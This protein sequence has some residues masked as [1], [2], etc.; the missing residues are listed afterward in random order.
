MPLQPY[1]A[2]TG[3]LLAPLGTLVNIGDS[4][5][6]PGIV[7]GTV[8]AG[9]TTVTGPNGD[10]F[11][12]TL[13][14]T[15]A[16]FSAGT[17]PIGVNDYHQSSYT[18]EL[19]GLDTG[20][21]SNVTFSRLISTQTQETIHLH[22]KTLSFKEDVKGWVSFKSFV[23]DA[24]IS[25]AS[26]YYTAFNGKLFKHHIEHV[27]RNHFYGSDYNSSINVILN[28]GPGSVKSFHTL[29]YEGSQSKV[30]GLKEMEIQDQA[31]ITDSTIT[32]DPQY[33]FFKVEDLNDI[34]EISNWNNTVFSIKHYTS[35]A[36]GKLLLGTIDVKAWDLT[37]SDSSQV[38]GWGYLEKEVPGGPSFQP[39]DIITTQS[40]EDSVEHFNMIPKDGWYVSN[41]ETNKQVGSLSEFIEKEG[42]WFNY[43]K[44][45]DSDIS[46]ESD[47]GAF[48]IQGLGIIKDI[49]SNKIFLDGDLNSS[50]Q[51]GDTIY[52]Q[53]ALSSS[54]HYVFDTIY[55]DQLQSAGVVS[56]IDPQSNSFH[57]VS[58]SGLSISVGDYIMF[59]KNHVV[60]MS[61][62]VGYFADVKF[63]N[64]S[65]DKVELFSVGSEIT[66]SS[67]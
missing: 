64:D 43:I 29:D 65:T 58:I 16:P 12:I 33:A 53:T 15:P 10:Y 38:M 41:I 3:I 4:V 62:L 11:E 32:P 19:T 1:W 59:A 30:N 28:D 7:P 21:T 31:F 25:M 55:S 20:Y 48:D 42:K 8:V 57:L 22:D 13:T 34:L 63:E 50:L 5:S 24:G 9:I 45:V 40:Q 66:E 44:G 35:E 49:I 2:P 51:V 17:V 23:P 27:N 6:G 37:N 60:N 56:Q 47:F 36:S 39:G 46:S 14:I 18:S 61:S 26:S 52:F 54:S 67:K